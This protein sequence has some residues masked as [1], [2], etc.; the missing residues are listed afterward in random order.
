MFRGPVGQKSRFQHFV[1]CCNWK[2]KFSMIL[3]RELFERDFDL[4]DY[5]S[6]FNFSMGFI[7]YSTNRCSTNLKKLVSQRSWNSDFWWFLVF[8]GHL[9]HHFQTFRRAAAHKQISGAKHSPFFLQFRWPYGLRFEGLRFCGYEHRI[10]TLFP[11][12]HFQRSNFWK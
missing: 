5:C 3:I 6:N 7:R 1:W 11:T 4:K 9:R 2:F 10:L 12:Y 8:S